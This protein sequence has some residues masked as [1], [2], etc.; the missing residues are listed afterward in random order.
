MGLPRQ[1]R[2]CRREVLLYGTLMG[3]ILWCAGAAVAQDAQPEKLVVAPGDV[4][5]TRLVEGNYASAAQQLRQAMDVTPDDATLNIAAGA[6]AIST[7]DLEMARAAFEHA[8]QTDSHDGLAHYGLGLAR[9][10]KG[11]R[12]GALSS[13][14][15]SE[16]EG[17]DRA[18]L[19]LARRYTQWLFGAQVAVAGAALPETLIPAQTV[20]QAM[21][22]QRAGNWREAAT[23]MQGVLASVPGDP[24]VEPGG[25]LMNFDPARPISTG[26]PRLPSGSLS[27]SP[28]KGSLIGSVEL[29]PAGSLEGVG[30]VSYEVD[31]HPLAIVNVKP[32]TYTW[33]TR[34]SKNGQHTLTVVLHDGAVNELARTNRKVRVVNAGADSGPAAEEA[35]SRMRGM[36]WQALALRP[37]R[38]SGAYALGLACRALGQTVAAQTWFARCLA[39]Q[40][41]YRDARKQWATCGGMAGGAGEAIWGGLS[42]EKVVALTFDDGPKPGVTEPLLDVLRQERVPATFFVIGRHV[43][44]YPELTK[45]IVEAG[46]EIAN[47]SYTHRNLTRLSQTEV[48]REVM[49]TQAAVQSVTGRAPRFLRPPGGNWNPRVARTARSWGLTPCMWTVDVYGSEVIGAQQVA[50][51]VLAQVRPGSIILMHNGKVSTLQALPTIIRALRSRGYAFATVDTKERRLGSARAAARIQASDV[52]HRGE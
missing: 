23:L 42:T 7:G 47:H 3:A 37:S 16:A 46:M 18:F 6:T 28:D 39:I 19:L 51:A 26:M 50:D 45:Q 49:Q 36:L 30:F 52:R 44:E 35:R 48:A 34:G 5:V 15:R 25:V 33:D 22:A 13:F 24:V 21:Q 9:L 31:G 29:S 43:M 1:R 40:A 32:F 10:A 27:V 14:D 8:L 12:V 11:D 20:L 2:T 17:G 4:A 41:D 38:C